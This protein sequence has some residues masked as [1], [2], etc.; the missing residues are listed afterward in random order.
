MLFPAVSI[1]ITF[2]GIIVAEAEQFILTTIKTWPLAEILQAV[3]NRL[4]PIN[5]RPRKTQ[6]MVG[7]MCFS[8]IRVDSAPIFQHGIGV[9][10]VGDVYLG[11]KGGRSVSHPRFL[12]QL[13]F[14]MIICILCHIWAPV[15]HQDP[16]ILD[17]LWMQM[18][19]WFWPWLT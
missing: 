14:M 19:R 7:S 10:I 17:A 1:N 2:I 13:R 12:W 5:K 9:L 15:I 16:V 3:V 8:S 6:V 18:K 4:K 11:W